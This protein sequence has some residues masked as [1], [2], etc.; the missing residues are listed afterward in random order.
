M[1]FL[2]EHREKFDN[3]F[4]ALS[5]NYISQIRLRANGGNSLLFDYPPEEELL[6][7][8]KAKE[9][10]DPEKVEFID[11]AKIFVSFIDQDGWE[12]FKEYYK[13]FK[14]TPDV[15]FNSNDEENDY[16]KMILKEI[17]T[18]QKKEKIPILIRT[19][20]LHGTGIGNTNIMEHK[21][22]MYMTLPLVIFYPSRIEN[23]NLMFLNFKPSSNYRCILVNKR[24]SL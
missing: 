3:L 14:D 8:N 23:D 18:V 22:I 16:L 19:G 9:L 1:A 24:S 13:D 10:L 11:L 12:D 17:E 4:G 6:Y 7:I 20:A 15:I 5:E 21:M 2:E